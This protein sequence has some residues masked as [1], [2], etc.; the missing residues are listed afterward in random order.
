MGTISKNFSF[1][2][3]EASDTAKEYRITNIITDAKVRDNIQA[4]VDNILQPLRDAVGV[5][6]R[7]SSGYRCHELNAKV[8]GVPTSQHTEGKAADVWCTVLDPL[9]LARAVL[10]E[11]LDFDQMGLYAGFLHIS[12]DPSK[13]E[14]RG[15]IFYHRS[16]QGR[17]FKKIG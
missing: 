5:P 3:F 16:Y 13:E 6:L 15:E 7:I 12:F 8:G 9:A 1:H 10:D 4:L 11:G 17:K 14:Q 2:E